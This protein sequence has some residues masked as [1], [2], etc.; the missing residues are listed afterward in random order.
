[1]RKNVLMIAYHIP[2]LKGS[3]GILRT[4]EFC[5]YLPEYGWNPAILSTN[6]KAYEHVDDEDI[7]S[8]LPH[9]PVVR[10]FALDTK[11]HLSIKSSYPIFLAIPDRWVSWFFSGVVSGLISIKK[12]KPSIIWST[13]PIATAHLIGYAL[14]RLSGLPWIADLRDPMAQDGYPE[15][16][17]QWNSFRWIENK[18]VRHASAICFTSPSAIIDF[19]N[20]HKDVSEKKLH[21]IENGYDEESFQLAE[22]HACQ[23]PPSLDRPVTLIHSGI[24]Y[25]SER[26]PKPFFEAI[27]KLKHQGSICNTSLRII[28]RATGHDNML[29][30]HL[31]SYGI[32]DIIELAPPLPYVEAL[33]EMINADGLILLQ[34]ANCNSQI[35]AKVYEYIRSGKP[36]FGLTD[37]NG[38]TASL[39]IRFPMHKICDIGSSELI[40]VEL[41]DFLDQ[42]K[43]KTDIKS[44]FLS[45]AKYS[46]E[47]RTKELANLL[48]STLSA[49]KIGA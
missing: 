31:T 37:I 2:P 25:P 21:L 36:I 39:L 18:I 20:Q 27:K 1:M 12:F 47:E 35:P 41:I 24:I 29:A 30:S 44:I 48:N 16:R 32:D 34:A 4:L 9:I 6:I 45:V 26:D 5:K 40:G 38:D 22:K 23:H 13:Y 42:I 8:I 15:N 11:R 7:E 28:L 17:L 3:S 10:A 46:R 49:V 33:A 43:N 19:L 14:H